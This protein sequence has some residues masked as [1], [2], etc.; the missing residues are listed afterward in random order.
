MNE[1]V[2]A[3]TNRNDQPGPDELRRQAEEMVSAKISHMPEYPDLSP[4]E[5][6]EALHELRV[7]QIE[8]EIQNEELRR[9]HVEL[10]AVRERYFDLYNLAPMGYITISETGLILEANLT[11]ATLLGVARG[12]LV[13]QPISR[14]IFKEDQDF[15]YL[16]RKKLFETGKPQAYELRMVKNVGMVF[17]A[18][19]ESTA[20][21]N[22]NG[23]LVSRVLLTD[24]T[25]LK[26]TQE[27]LQKTHEQLT[28]ALYA[29]GAGGWDWDMT[30]E[31]IKWA[32]ELF[33]LFG[34]DPATAVAG[35]ETWRGIL[36]PD[37]RESAEQRIIAAIR[38]HIQL[39]N[40]YRI[41]FPSGEIRWISSLGDTTYD[42]NGKSLRMA[43]ICLD[44]S[45]RKQT[46]AIKT[47][48]EAQRMQI[49]KSAS[50]SRMAGAIA[51]TFNN[52]LA[53]VIGNLEL[54]IFKQSNDKCSV[55]NLTEAI[56]A[57]RRASEVTSQLLIYLGQ[58]STD[59][60]VLDFPAV[61]QNHL[62]ILRAAMPKN[63]I[64]ETNLLSPGY[65]IFGNENQILQ[66]ITNLASNAWEAMGNFDGTIRLTVKTVVSEEIPAAYHFPFDWQP[67]DNDYICLEVADTGYGIPTQDMGNI[68]DP[69]FSNKFT[70]RG[71]G[72]SVVLGIVRA[73]NGVI[74]IES[75]PG[76]GSVFRIFLPKYGEEVLQ[77]PQKTP[78]IEISES[79]AVLLVED[80]E[81]MRSITGEILTS[82]GFT[83]F[84]AK[85]GVE[86]IEVFRQH[87]DE[88]RFVL[89]D[90]TMPH[91]NGWETLVALRKLDP[92]ITVILSSGY[93]EAEVMA[94]EHSEKPQAF[95][96][97][98]Y[99]IN[100]LRIA[101]HLALHGKAV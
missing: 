6:R 1:R 44:I 68:F 11:A 100:D 51:H 9:A 45:E 59:K 21:Q 61:C 77:P 79:G 8:L 48:F 35:F 13:K 46:E 32:P 73:H 85:D 17:W 76:K 57:A 33:R 38:D 90:L 82:L 4:E 49:Q 66:V 64:L 54:T 34:L 81:M 65:K 41:I 52:L 29:A 80:E 24:I 36:H 28:F 75:E 60:V 26:R 31:Q 20:T 98:P 19:L 22:D 94:G 84:S 70:G 83:V 71:L 95:L 56:N 47:T 30:T 67:Q 3:M 2:H 93:D 15:Y 37:D 91:M 92:D 23:D 97:K 14:F 27:A 53:V 50:L 86:A 96:S 101:I 62:P 63:V 40:E 88:I 7:H 74:T 5:A 18:H 10:D 55:E 58:S 16:N 43:G 69:F 25:D 72:L 78:V 42:A 39:E 12:M 99:K 87:A 89:C